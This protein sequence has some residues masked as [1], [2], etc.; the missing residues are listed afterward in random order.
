MSV[1][2]LF[3]YLPSVYKDNLV[4]SKGENVLISLFTQ[5]TN[6]IGSMIYEAQQLSQ[7]PYLETCPLFI[8]EYYKT[9]DVSVANNI[10]GN[11]YQIDST[12]IGFSDLYYDGNLTSLALSS[13]NFTIN[14]N[15]ST[16]IRYITLPS[17]LDPKVITLFTK[18]CYH[19]KNLLYNIFG[20]LL[21]YQP[22]FS[23]LPYGTNYLIQEQNYKNQL[24]GLLYTSVKGQ[25]VESISTGLSLFL[26]LQYAT[27]N[28]IVRNLTTTSITLEN[29]SDGT[30]TTVNGNIDS[31]LTIGTIISKYTILEIKN[32]ILYDQFVDPARFT[33][34]LL[35]NGSEYLLSLL[36]IDI[37][38]QEKYAHLDF[39]TNLYYDDENL[40]WDMGD[41]T[42]VDNT[43]PSDATIYSI[44]SAGLVTNF[45][46]YNDS[47]F[48]SQKIY[49]MFRN[50]FILEFTI[51][52]DSTTIINTANFLT[53]FKPLSSRYIIYNPS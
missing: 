52:Q 17:A 10:G 15:T 8:K 43:L 21:N 37:T 14:H 26:G 18:T 53:R 31:I 50:L 36:N 2:F 29:S 51:H 16:N 47:R 9:I 45:S 6:C 30:L 44:P 46:S 41:N 5:Y 7:A 20:K 27:A 1:D 49:E 13:S 40:Y 35:A 48:Q 19:Q 28:S 3:D 24:L 23:F 38:N 12:I 4:N 11:N 22:T 34:F 33:Q 39:D 42:G 32:F 25:T